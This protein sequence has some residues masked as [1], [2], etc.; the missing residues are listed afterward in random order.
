MNIIDLADI[1]IV[2]QLCRTST[3]FCILMQNRSNDGYVFSLGFSYLLSSFLTADV[4]VVC[5][6]LRHTRSIANI[7]SGQ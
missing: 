2:E 6:A 4:H 3:T 1:I 5:D 7:N